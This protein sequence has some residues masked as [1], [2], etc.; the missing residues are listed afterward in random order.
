MV[1]IWENTSVALLESLQVSK[2]SWI[3]LTD[4]R[5][6]FV[7]INQNMFADMNIYILTGKID[8]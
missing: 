4:S 2:D 6:F 1:V 7:Y 8:H 3:N 5:Y